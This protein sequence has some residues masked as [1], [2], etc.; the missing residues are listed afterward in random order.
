MAGS[1]IPGVCLGL[2]L[3]LCATLPVAGAVLGAPETGQAAVLFHPS[4]TPSQIALAAAGAGVD[5]VRFGRA[6]GTVI[7]NIE[8][9]AGQAALRQAGAWLIADP[10]ILGG[11]TA[12]QSPEELR[13]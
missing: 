3:T 2:C 12:A 11:C 5:I 8:T 9:P 6:P 7:V 10:V 1:S 4:S 13:S